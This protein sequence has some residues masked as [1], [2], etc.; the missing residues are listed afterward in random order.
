MKRTRIFIVS[1]I[2][3][4]FALST[5]YSLWTYSSI[6]I[7][8]KISSQVG[9]KT[10]LSNY[11][12]NYLP[13]EA[14]VLEVVKETELQNILLKYCGSNTTVKVGNVEVEGEIMSFDEYKVHQAQAFITDVNKRFPKKDH[15]YHLKSLLVSASKPV[16]YF[17]LIL[18]V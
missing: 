7:F 2:I 4:S 13:E 8:Q 18:A 6:K 1:A 12:T 16:C 9:A 14:E 11:L 5:L 3:S 17:C 10:G 15:K